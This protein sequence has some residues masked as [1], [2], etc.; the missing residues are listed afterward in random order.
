MRKERALSVALF[1]WL[2]WVSTASAAP[3]DT[4]SKTKEVAQKVYLQGVDHYR[5]GRVLEALAAFRASYELV[6]SP[7][8]HLM[9]ARA[10][11]DHGDLIDAYAEYHKLVVEADATA[12]QDSKYDAAVQ[13]S[14][15]ERATLRARLTMV[16]VEVKDPPDDVRV[17]IGGRQIERDDWGKSVAVPSGSIVVRATASGRP[18]QR[19]QLTAIPGGELEVRFDFA[20]PDVPPA[21]SGL[22]SWA[23]NG[24]DARPE[25]S[26]FPSSDAI[27]DIPRQPEQPPTPP[28]DRT[29]AY[30]SFGVGGAGLV[31]FVVFGAIDQSVFGDLQRDCPGGH[32]PP[33][34]ASDVDKGR[35]MQLIANIGFGTA[36]AGATLGCVLLAN[37]E[38][39]SDRPEVARQTRKFAVTDVS[40]DSHG[41]RVGG[42]F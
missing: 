38:T 31:T 36:L 6:P 22:A 14:R 18:E 32:C 26:P 7:N 28:P 37:G 17:V 35:Q 25:A 34:R 15:A 41:V 23:V 29:W 19:Q 4:S 42:E 33:S 27:P 40:I 24:D 30:V 2:T 9:L 13:A 16:T 3:R 1:A 5:A 21:P 20:E 8:S 39:G 12:A 11:R 10:L